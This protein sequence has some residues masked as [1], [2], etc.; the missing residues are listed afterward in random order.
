[1]KKNDVSARFKNKK[2]NVKEL[3]QK[4]KV[5]RKNNKTN[6]KGKSQENNFKNKGRK[7]NSKFKRIYKVQDYQNLNEQELKLMELGII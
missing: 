2:R 3:S 5:I 4:E 6:K 7:R 1:M